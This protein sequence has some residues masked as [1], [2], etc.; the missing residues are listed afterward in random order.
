MQ[1][2][3]RDFLAAVLDASDSV[4]FVIDRESRVV[5]GNEAFGRLAG[6]RP[7]DAVGRRLWEFDP[8]HRYRDEVQ[9]LVRSVIADRRPRRFDQEWLTPQQ[10]VRTYEWA[11]SP[12]ID[13]H[14]EV[15]H[16]VSVGV[17]ATL[18]KRALQDAHEAEERFRAFFDEAPIGKSLTSPDGRVIRVNQALCSMLGY[19]QEELQQKGYA[20]LTH[21]DDLALTAEFFRR[22]QAGGLAGATVEKRYLARD[23]RVVWALVRTTLHRDRDGVPTYCLTHVVDITERR[24]AE[25]ERAALQETVRQER[26]RLQ[27]LVRSM[28][29]EVW[30]ADA[31][32]DFTLANP[33]ALREFGLPSIDGMPVREL[34]TSLEVLRPDGSPRPIE[35][36]P[37]LRALEG[38]TVTSQEELVRTP[39]YG[40]LRTRQV[41]AAPVRD[42]RGAI[43][44]AVCVVRDVTAERQSQQLMQRAQ[45]LESIGLLAGGIAHDFNNL[46]T[47][48]L[49][50]TSLARIDVQP[51]SP[52]DRWLTEVE[53]AVERAQDLTRQLLT[54]SKGG[55]PVRKVVRLDRL[56]EDAATFSVRGTRS[57]CE[58][59]IPEVPWPVEVDEGQIGQVVS[60]LVVNAAEAM[61]DGGD[62]QVEVLNVPKGTIPGLPATP[63]VEIAV[64]D[65]GSGVPPEIASRIFDPYFT[66]KPNGSGLGLATS[67]AIVRKHGGTI[68]LE[69][70]PGRGARFRVFLPASDKPLSPSGMTARS[71]AVRGRILVMDDDEPIRFVCRQMLLHLGCEVETAKDGREAI[72]KYQA[73]SG[74]PQRFDVV[75][76]DLT[77]PCGMG[78]LE[79]FEHLRR[80]DPAVKAIVSSGYSNDPVLSDFRQF[81]FAGIMPK[82]YKMEAL[83]KTLAA[84]LG[85]AEPSA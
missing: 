18:R 12:L 33:S 19:T 16:I 6:T 42:A 5:R 70:S 25:E 84:V 47:G 35:E 56:V 28:V 58:V 1:P 57:R 20:D 40:E 73:A 9:E 17:D 66:T 15:T 37:A 78:G 72:T 30:F 68:T 34:A 75:I 8:A 64:K 62:V 23:G 43:V 55:A 69:S 60:N 29:D 7:A 79:A 51:G 53:G 46:L 11:L 44:G 63:H 52:A 80:M 67:E 13:A 21:P 54:Y 4:I 38:Q 83:R 65:E 24:R 3:D 10:D 31:N 32:G 41:S 61:P 45:R 81:G 22:L 48:I 2:D 59:R 36:S 39:L 85:P 82:P 49:G 50:N 77:V 14:G 27:A 76:L 71:A 74:T 26:D